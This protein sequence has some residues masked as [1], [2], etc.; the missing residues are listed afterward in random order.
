M[1]NTWENNDHLNH[2]IGLALRV[3]KLFLSVR[4][5]F[6]ICRKSVEISVNDDGN[7]RARRRKKNKKGVIND[8]LVQPH[9]Q[10]SCVHLACLIN[11]FCFPR[12]WIVSTV[13]TD[14]LTNW[15]SGR[16]SY[17]KI[18]TTTGRGLAKWIKIEEEHFWHETKEKAENDKKVHQ[19]SWGPSSIQGFLE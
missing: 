3:N 15:W 2:L 12:F 7:V 9:T 13:W 18:V 17:V 1:S 5:S 10:T 14:Y 16:T 19:R 6:Y 11:L 4:P 8:P